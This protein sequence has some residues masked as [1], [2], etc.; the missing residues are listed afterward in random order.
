MTNFLVK[1]G[2]MKFNEIGIINVS[3]NFNYF[4]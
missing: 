2:G 4:Y 1:K 3:N